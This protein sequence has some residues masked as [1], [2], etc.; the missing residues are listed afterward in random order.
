[1]Q[2]VD[3]MLVNFTWRGWGV[4]QAGAKFT[5]EPNN[6]AGVESCVV[7]NKSQSTGSSSLS[8][9]GWSDTECDNK[10]AFLCRNVCEWRTPLP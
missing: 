8:A 7:A 5:A 10:F 2:T 3:R 9:C 6:L 1:M 4:H